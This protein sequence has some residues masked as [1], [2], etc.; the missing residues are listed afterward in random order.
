MQKLLRRFRVGTRLW[1]ILGI[2]FIGFVLLGSYSLAT[3]FGLVLDE[4]E[5]GAAYVVESAVTVAE[6]YAE[7][8]EAGELTEAEARDRAA[9]AIRHMRYNEYGDGSREYVWIMDRGP[10]MV[11][12]PVS[13]E[14]EGQNLHDL[15]DD[16][17]QYFIRE[18]LDVVEADGAGFVEYLWPMP[19][20][21]RDEPV[22]KSTYFEVYEPW[23]WVV[24]SGV[25]LE[26]GRADLAGF[27]MNFAGPV[28]AVLAV[29]VGFVFLVI[30][31][32]VT[33]L[34]ATSRE[35]QAMTG[36][37]VDL[38]R[39]IRLDGQDEVTEVAQSV[40]ALTQTSRK[41]LRAASEARDDL[42]HSAQTLSAVTEQATRGI[43]RQRSES[44]ELATAMNEMVSTV[45]EV[46]RNTNS[47]ADSA[48]EAEE[49]TSNGR[50]V[51]EQTVEAIQ[52]LA[53]ELERTQQSVE[54]LSGESEEIRSIVAAINEITEQ[55]NLLALNAAIEAARAGESGRGFAVVADEVR[56][57]SGRTQESTQQIQEIAERFQRGSQEAVERMSASSEKAGNTVQSSS[58]AGDSLNAITQAVST[59]SDLNTQIASAA[60]QQASTAEEINRN[61]VNIR[62]VANET[63]GGV[64]QIAEAAERQ[65]QLVERLQEE[66]GRIR[67]D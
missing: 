31:S 30:R 33:P 26:R 48:R 45:Q 14:L 59:I 61:V 18:A 4:R 13:P 25:Y 66:L 35:I 9:D 51:V 11:M 64:Q 44:E 6:R 16:Q 65:R 47:A 12:H 36:N 49:A 34:T 5:Q 41:A 8:A 53:H 2:G 10:E 50:R 7:R 17:G 24:A 22:V 3:A 39:E 54:T 20:E 52:D 56:K 38:T 55:T 67:Y 46:A 63:H 40:N 29:V 27:A 32:I 58:Q 19:G 42:Q 37:P 57:L 62:D 43:E 23:D 1:A 60:E 15:Q 21:D 28:V